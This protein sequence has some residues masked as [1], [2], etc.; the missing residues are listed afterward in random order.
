[1][2]KITV[3]GE[4]VV[5]TS[6]MTLEDIKT[7]EKYRPNSLVLMG[8]ED[9]KEPV[10]AVGTTKG[11]GEINAFGASFGCETHEEPHKACI[12]ML[13]GDVRGDVKDWVADKFGLA[14][15]NLNKVEAMIPSVLEEIAEEK[16][17]ILENIVLA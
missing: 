6:E 5:V 7:V 14:I 3:V 15:M 9:N 1:M 11:I 17:A 2:A 12:T 4:A 16:A 8:G 13:L 10:F